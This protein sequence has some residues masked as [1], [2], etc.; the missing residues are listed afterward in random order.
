MKENSDILDKIELYTKGKMRLEE[1]LAFEKELATDELVREQFEF[2]QIVDQMIIGN[3]TLKLKEQMQ[4]DLY[5][6][7]SNIGKYLAVSLFALIASAGL[8]F[9]F[10]KKEENVIKEVSPVTGVPQKINQIEKQVEIQKN[11][12]SAKTK[13]AVIQENKSSIKS[14]VNSPNTSESKVASVQ[15]EMV[16]NI[17]VPTSAQAISAQN[18]ASKQNVTLA[19]KQDPCASLEGDVE[20]YTSPSCKG[21]ETGEVH[22]KTETVKGGLAPFTFTIGDRKAKNHIDRLAAGQYSLFI[23]DANGCSVENVKKVVVAEKKCIN[24]IEYVYNPEYDSSWPIPYDADKQATSVKI[25]EKG[26]KVFFQTAV[27]SSQPTEWKGESNT[28]L[29]L[30]MGIYFFTIEYADGS[31]DEG[32]IVVTR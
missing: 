28:G 15:P 11:T 30:G 6:T 27:S 20:F 29:T 18:V 1:K 17:S 8:F 32:S 3:E 4:K 23:K 22:L 2:S 24:K 12:I 31:V 26:G 9:V 13:T 21:Q 19:L 7:K 16:Q 25:L 10:D 14:N 5:N